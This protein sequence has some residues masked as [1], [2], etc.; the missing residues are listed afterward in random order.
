MHGPQYQK[1][2]H[3]RQR[4]H[5]LIMISI[6]CCLFPPPFVDVIRQDEQFAHWATVVEYRGKFNRF[7]LGASITLGIRSTTGAAST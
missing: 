5:Y 6:L 1:L 4:Y 2:S 7:C 3:P